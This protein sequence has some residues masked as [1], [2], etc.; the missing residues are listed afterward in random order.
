MVPGIPV[1]AQDVEYSYDNIPHVIATRDLTQNQ[2]IIV[3]DGAGRVFLINAQV[4]HRH[5]V[6]SKTAP[7]VASDNSTLDDQGQ[8]VA[9]PRA[10]GRAIMQWMKGRARPAIWMKMSFEML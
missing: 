8:V 1:E 6:E 9:K 2:C 10:V 5:M 4:C 3:S 7:A